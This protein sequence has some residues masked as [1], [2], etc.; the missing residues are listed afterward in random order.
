MAPKPTDYINYVWIIIIFI[1]AAYLYQ[2][3]TAKQFNN[4]TEQENYSTL[5]KYLI[6][7]GTTLDNSK[8]E[9]PILWIPLHYEYNSRNWQSFGSRS[10]FDLNQPYLY[11]TVKSIINQ[12]SDSFRICL[13]DDES[14]SKLLPNWK[15]NMGGISSPV[16]DYMRQLGLTSLL[17]HYGGLLVPASFLCFRDL[18]DMYNTGTSNNKICICETIDRNITSTSYNWYPNLYFMGAQ[19]GAPVLRELMD[20]MQRTISNDYTAQA[21]FLGDFNRWIQYRVKKHQV[22]IIDGKMIGTRTMEDEPIIVDDLLSN[23]Y[24]DIYASAYGIYIPADEILKRTKYEWFARLSQRQVLESKVIICKYILL[25]NTP[26]VQKGVIE[27]FKEKP[28]KHPWVSFWRMPLG[29][30][31]WGLKPNVSPNFVVQESYPG[32][33]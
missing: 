27:P 3:Y 7:D 31:L 13:I 15:I 12:C 4:T 25:A 18:I 26:N 14:F 28:K 19:K 5:Q 10:S 8:D 22:T 6:N 21:E 29:A 24:L 1:V 20:F 9:R 33:L 17:N 16:L 23:N 32:K 30:P 11:L 2:R